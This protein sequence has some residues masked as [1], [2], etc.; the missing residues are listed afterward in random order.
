MNKVKVKDMATSNLLVVIPA[1]NEAL[2]IANVLG[3]LQQSCDC[4]VVVI[5]DGSTDDTAKIA[6]ACGAVV[7]PV[8][9]VL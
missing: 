1:K 8:L 6:R 9:F 2:T 3:Q 5:D 4:D 7:L